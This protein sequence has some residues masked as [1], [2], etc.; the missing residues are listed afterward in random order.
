MMAMIKINNS[1]LL[2]K[3]RWI[4][5]MQVHYEVIL[6]GPEETAEERHSRKLPSAR[7]NLGYLVWRR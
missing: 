1:E 5:L 4:L 6:E 7:R 2:K 3:I